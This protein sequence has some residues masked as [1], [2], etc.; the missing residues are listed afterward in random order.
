[1]TTERF[2]LDAGAL[3]A[4]GAPTYGAVVETIE[5]FPITFNEAALSD[6][7]ILCYYAYSPLYAADA[8]GANDQARTALLGINHC[9]EPKLT[10]SLPAQISGATTL[11]G[12]VQVPRN[13]QY[14]PAPNVLVTYAATC[15]GV[16]P[17]QRP[18][19]CQ[20][21]VQHHCDTECGLCARVRRGRGAG[22]RR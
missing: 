11:T 10:A 18:H 22:R 2:D 12:T 5:S 3:D 7:Q 20:R 8:G 17:R 9:V 1:M 13:G 6:I 16:A 21:R 4:N 15:A 14:V 19:R